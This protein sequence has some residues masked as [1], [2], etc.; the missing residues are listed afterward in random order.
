L[1][2]VADA[3]AAANVEVGCCHNLG[4]QRRQAVEC[5]IKKM[6]SNRRGDDR[7]RGRSGALLIGEPAWRNELSEAYV[8]AAKAA[9][10]PENPDSTAPSRRA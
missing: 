5:N 4:D 10:L 8:A 7:F 6:E 3:N 1:L 9:D 2:A